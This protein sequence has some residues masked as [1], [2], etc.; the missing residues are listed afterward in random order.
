MSSDFFQSELTWALAMPCRDGRQNFSCFLCET[1][2]VD[3][4]CYVVMYNVKTVRT[5][6]S[7][8]FSDR[9]APCCD[10]AAPVV[11]PRVAVLCVLGPAVGCLGTASLPVDLA[12]SFS[13]PPFERACALIPAPAAFPLPSFLSAP[14]APH[15]R[16]VF[17]VPL[18]FLTFLFVLYNFQH[19]GSAFHSFKA[20]HHTHFFCCLTIP[21]SLLHSFHVRSS[22]PTRLEL[23]LEHRLYIHSFLQLRPAR[24]LQPQEIRTRRT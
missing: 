13:I 14:L 12:P 1:V 4:C 2:G 18:S 5:C 16:S 8:C 17:V 11:V 15:R 22:V 7:T 19:T 20:V 3:G 21:L 24:I 10:M 23:V 6:S 9:Q